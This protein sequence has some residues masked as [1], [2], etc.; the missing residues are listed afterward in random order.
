[1]MSREDTHT[2]HRKFL[3][4]MD[5]Y[6]FIILFLMVAC[7]FTWSENVMITRAI[8][9]VGRMGVLISSYMVYRMILNYGAV[10]SL[11]WNNLFA[12][13]LYASYLLLGFISFMWSTNVGVSALQWF[14][15]TQ[16]MIF[17]YFFINSLI[18]LDEYFPDHPM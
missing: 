2:N 8:K 10:D 3:R 13:M 4:K 11:R 15:T 18:I 5:R 7:F 9:V 16:S 12:P 17:C 6:L 14:M 1:M